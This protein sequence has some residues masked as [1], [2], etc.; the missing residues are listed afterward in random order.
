VH[1]AVALVTIHAARICAD[2]RNQSAALT[3]NDGVQ[4]F[5]E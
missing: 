4:L 5:P 2:E 1:C 3:L